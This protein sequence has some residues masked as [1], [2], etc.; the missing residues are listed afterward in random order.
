MQRI[1]R[2]RKGLVRVVLLIRVHIPHDRRCRARDDAVCRAHGVGVP[3]IAHG[4]DG[5]VGR[6]DDEGGDVPPKGDGLARS[7]FV[8]RSGSLRWLGDEDPAGGCTLRYECY[9]CTG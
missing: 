5:Q 9:G 4:G 2:L 3:V 6:G 1:R 7:D 8:E